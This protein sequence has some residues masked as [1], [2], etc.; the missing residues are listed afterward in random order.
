MENF[1]SFEN[2]EV[3]ELGAGSGIAA[4]LMAKRGARVTLVDFSDEALKKSLDFYNRARLSAEFI[5]ADVLSLPGTL[6]N[7]FRV[8]MSFGL[9]EHFSGNDRMGVIKSHLDVLRSGGMF[10]VSV[11][12]AHNL[13]YRIYIFLVEMM[14]K[15][16][17]PKEYPF[18]RMEFKAI[19]RHLHID[20]Y[21]FLGSSL[22]SSFEFIDP[23]KLVR[24]LF[25]LKP[26]LPRVSEERGTFLDQYLGYALVL[27][28]KK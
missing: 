9:A 12:N 22:F 28:G 6:L 13:P 8:S 10:F 11:P 15:W 18:S 25:K 23:S 2:L 26:A 20:Q 21:F 16:G 19:C 5:N 24:K 3:I 27:C 7:R 1:G 4:A 14:K 17:V